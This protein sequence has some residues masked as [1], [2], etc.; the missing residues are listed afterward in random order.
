MSSYFSCLL[1]MRAALY[2]QGEDLHFAV[3]PGGLHNTQDITCFVAKE[4]RSFVASVSGVLR[5]SDIPDD[6]PNAWILKDRCP[7]QM[8]TGGSCIA[9]PDGQWVAYEGNE[10][11]PFEIY[12]RRYPDGSDKQTISR[13]GGT[14]PKWAPAELAVVTVPGPIKAAVT[15]SP[16]PKRFPYP[17]MANRVLLL[18]P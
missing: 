15:S 12:V 9:A 1:R 3:W 6:I 16:G 13:G 5:N 8:A 17:V 18:F 11:G 4:S 10:S 14:N 7:E 2:G